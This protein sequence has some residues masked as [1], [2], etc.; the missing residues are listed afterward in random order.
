MTIL[1]GGE[2]KFTDLQTSF[3]LT[4]GNLSSH[5]T[6]LEQAGY[7][8]VKKSF[9]GKKPQTSI[10]A[11]PKGKKALKDYIANMKSRLESAAKTLA[12]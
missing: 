12:T 8:K 3:K 5:L 11:T 2:E 10:E 7:V 6:Q 9:L 4:S 1:A